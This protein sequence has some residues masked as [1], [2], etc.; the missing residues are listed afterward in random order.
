M[1]RRLYVRFNVFLTLHYLEGE[2]LGLSL[3]PLYP[4]EGTS[5]INWTEDYIRHQSDL[6]KKA[7]T[8]IFAPVGNRNHISQ[9]V[10]SHSDL[11]AIS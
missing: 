2:W 6:D 1:Y 9:T 7:F 4:E 8:N 11:V 3:P 10:T 5:G